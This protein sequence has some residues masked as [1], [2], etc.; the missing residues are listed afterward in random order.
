MASTRNKNTPGNYTLEIEGKR[1]Q[2]QYKVNELYS[3]P[4]ETQFFGDGLLPG[5][6][7]PAK[8]STNYCDI[9]SDLRGIGST[10]LVQP[11]SPVKP[12]INQLKSLNMI[13][14]VP[15]IFPKSYEHSNVERPFIGLTN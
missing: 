13:D 8:L 5:R 3:V 1:E 15:L 10:N 4:K 12:D 2:A 11:Q 9:E 7:G 6:V 14:R